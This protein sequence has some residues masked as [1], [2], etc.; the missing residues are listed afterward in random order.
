MKMIVQ[1]AIALIS[2]R[3]DNMPF[4]VAQKGFLF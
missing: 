4:T 1:S 2:E 3:N